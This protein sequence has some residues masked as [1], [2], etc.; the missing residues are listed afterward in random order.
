MDTV[1]NKSELK[2]E[3]AILT[4][5]QYSQY[6]WF[7]T[8]LIHHYFQFVFRLQTFE[9]DKYFN[10]CLL[11]DTSGL[12]YCNKILVNSHSCGIC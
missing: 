9:N 8:F 12:I 5:L 2:D 1:W 4:T 7:I 10:L 11:V 6:R 3:S